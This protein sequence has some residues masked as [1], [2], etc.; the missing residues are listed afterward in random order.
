M[1]LSHE[2][3]FLFLKTRKTAGSSLEKCLLPHLNPET[4]ICTGGSYEDDYPSLNYPSGWNT[5]L[6]LS[7]LG[8]LINS[9]Q[10]LEILNNYFVFTIERNP[11]DKVV[12]MYFWMQKTRPKVFGDM[13]FSQF[14][15]FK[16][17]HSIGLD[18]HIYF[19]N[20]YRPN[21]IYDFANL[22]PIRDKLFQKGIDIRESF[23][24]TRLKNNTNQTKQYSKMY[25]NE[26][27]IFI[28]HNRFKEVVDFMG[29]TYD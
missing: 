14:V 13:N 19:Y 6:E 25:K 11:W 29:Y 26:N 15:R 20:E 18:T 16:N 10:F 24:K 7:E 4:D 17:V 3:K 22:D 8:V 12:S 27:D 21:K 28:V 5:H 2:H 23:S 9:L 1:I